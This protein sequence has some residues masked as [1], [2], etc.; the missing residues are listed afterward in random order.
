M[1]EEKGV[2]G[3]ANIVT[4]FFYSFTISTGQ[5]GPVSELLSNFVESFSAT[6]FL[7][8]LPMFTFP[9]LRRPTYGYI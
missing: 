4:F 3:Q 2:E 6:L 8:A 1:E 5:Y 9:I 7:S